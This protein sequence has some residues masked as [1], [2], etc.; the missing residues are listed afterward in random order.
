MHSS[1]LVIFG[2]ALCWL[3]TE[4]NNKWIVV[5]KTAYESL[6]DKVLN[7]NVQQKTFYENSFVRI[8][9]YNNILTKTILL[10]CIAHIIN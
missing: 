5:Y 10:I 2:A 3:Y 8:K 7:K 6:N 1:L 4:K 9:R